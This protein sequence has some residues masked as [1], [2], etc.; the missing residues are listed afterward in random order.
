[1]MGG[2]RTEADTC[3]ECQQKEVLKK[4]QEDNRKQMNGGPGYPNLL[5]K[6]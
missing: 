6:R 3:A 4:Q 1:M 5:S 2:L